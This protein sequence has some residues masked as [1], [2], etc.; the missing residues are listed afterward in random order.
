MTFHIKRLKLNFCYGF[1]QAMSMLHVMFGRNPLR[2][3]P[4]IFQQ[5]QTTPR[6]LADELSVTFKMCLFS[7]SYG[8]TSH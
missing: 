2:G 4:I 8:Y 3:L 6:T 7:V 1:L 5:L